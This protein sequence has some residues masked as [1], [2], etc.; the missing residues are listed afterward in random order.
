[1]HRKQP[2][3][4]LPR[5]AARR[6]PPKLTCDGEHLSG[7]RP[8][9][10]LNN[11]EQWWTISPDTSRRRA[12]P[13]SHVNCPSKGYVPI[14][15]TMLHSRDRSR[16]IY[17]RQSRPA[18]AYAAPSASAVTTRRTAAYRAT[19]PSS[20][21]WPGAALGF[22]VLPRPMAFASSYLP[23]RR[24]L[25]F[26]ALALCASF[27]TNKSDRCSLSP[28]RLQRSVIAFVHAISDR[29]RQCSCS[30]NITFPFRASIL[31]PVR[32]SLSG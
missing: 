23:W 20:I 22:A 17:R 10:T 13:R 19:A 6:P 3:R 9:H 11:G 21:T 2:P 28:C 15:T 32:S 5:S 30:L 24:I 16:T 31:R 26:R 1:M 4:E 25:I 18:T 12:A 14:S 27:K 29:Y 7:C 8:R